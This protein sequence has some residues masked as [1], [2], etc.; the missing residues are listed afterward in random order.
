[1][2]FL[3]LVLCIIIYFYYVSSEFS[4]NLSNATFFSLLN[5]F[6]P[7]CGFAVSLLNKYVETIMQY[8]R[9]SMLHQNWFDV[10][11]N[12]GQFSLFVNS[13]NNN[14]YIYAFE[15]FDPVYHALYLKVQDIPNIRLNHIAISNETG[16][17]PLYTM[18]GY[19]NSRNEESSLSS[20]YK[21]YYIYQYTNTSTLADFMKKSNIS[22]IFFMKIDTEG[23]DG[24]IINSS[25]K[26]F[27]EGK[28]KY[29]Y[30]EYHSSWKTTD[31]TLSIKD[32]VKLL[33]SCGY[34]VYIEYSNA[35]YVNETII[36]YIRIT[37]ETFCV[38][39]FAIRKGSAYESDIMRRLCPKC[40]Y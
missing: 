6:Y 9:T 23:Y 2:Y 25:R 22:D 7:G 28:I 18:R 24:A 38:N 20:L 10:G 16:I 34:N 26:V 36:D 27:E 1:M 30:F 33:G 35:L 37:S 40:G 13:V 17:K 21:G 15:P 14:A 19:E 11:S 31:P 12:V 39:F 8:D 5:E 32:I 29:L 4:P 3:R